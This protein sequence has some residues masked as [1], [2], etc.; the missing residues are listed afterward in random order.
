[1]ELILQCQSLL[2]SKVTPNTIRW[3]LKL[4]LNIFNSRGTMVKYTVEVFTGDALNAGNANAV[5]IKLIGTKGSSEPQILGR[6]AG[7]LSSS[8]S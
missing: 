4:F 8:V 7:M 3:E 1:M 6:F 5:F 2:R